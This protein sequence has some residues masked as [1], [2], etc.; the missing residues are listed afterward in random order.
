MTWFKVDDQL[1]FNMKV[2]SAGNPA[3]GLWVRAGS[4]SAAQLS[5]G[6]VPAPIV[7]ALGGSTE[8]A[9]SLVAVGLWHEVEGGWEFHDW[10]EYQPTKEQVLAQRKSTAERV[11]KHRAKRGGNDGGNES[12]NGVEVGVRNGVTGGATSDVSAGVSTAAPTRPDPT[13]VMTEVITGGKPRKR[14]TRIPDPFV[15]TADMR[16]WAADRT[17]LVNVDATTERFVNYWRAKAGKDATKLDWLATW[18][19]WLLR[20]QEDRSTRK[21][22]P[23]ERAKQTVAAG[24]ELAGIAITSLELGAAS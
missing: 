6:I 22:T 11:A 23:T 21:L 4:W 7:A 8:D 2:L 15:V 14:G 3:M 13:P 17:P 9:A 10:A 24:R 19:N 16:A 1:A 20:D 18:Q 5:D 12:G